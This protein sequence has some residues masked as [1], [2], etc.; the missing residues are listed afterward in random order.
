MGRPAPCLPLVFLAYAAIETSTS[1][2]PHTVRSTEVQ[3]GLRP[4]VSQLR[5]SHPTPLPR[6]DPC[7]IRRAPAP[8]LTLNQ[9]CVLD[10][11]RPEHHAA[12]LLGT[13]RCDLPAEAGR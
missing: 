3:L 2:L 11:T 9:S 4:Y 6:R 13:S 12:V 8:T 1:W 5:Q 7:P 10:H